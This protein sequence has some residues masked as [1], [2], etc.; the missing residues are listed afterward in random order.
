MNANTSWWS[1]FMSCYHGIA[2]CSTL[3]LFDLPPLQP[4][5]QIMD[6]FLTKIFCDLTFALVYAFAFVCGCAPKFETILFYCSCFKVSFCN[7]D[8]LFFFY[9]TFFKASYYFCVVLFFRAFHCFWRIPK[10]LVRPKM[11]LNYSNSGIVRNSGHV[12][13]F[14][15]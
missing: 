8:S 6:D 11:G 1:Q 5:P 7:R 14:Q 10:F 9:A 4:F 2:P 15:H 12:P 13:N 3:C